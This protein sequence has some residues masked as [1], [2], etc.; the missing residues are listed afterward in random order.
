MPATQDHFERAN[1]APTAPRSGLLLY[2]ADCRLCRAL[3]A[4]ALAADRRGRLRALPLQSA[5]AR[6]ALPSISDSE[7]LAS[8]H[9]VDSDGHHSATG[10]ALTRILALLPG[11][12]V[13][14]AA[15]AR[16]PRLAEAGYRLVA[17]NRGRLGQL[18]PARALA[19]ADR[20]LS[21][22][23]PRP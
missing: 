11:G 10:D 2:D 12:R 8:M 23:A 13:P 19:W 17:A 6:R 21:G 7:R 5:D 1:S 22:R 4:A 16:T 3:A 20:R 18:L 15:L 9:F 14:A